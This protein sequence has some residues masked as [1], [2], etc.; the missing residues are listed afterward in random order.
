MGKP[1]ISIVM[2]SHNDEP[3]IGRTLAG[4]RSQRCSRSFEI[5][6]IDDSSTDRTRELIADYPDVRRIDPP[7]GVY[8]PG[9][10]LNAAVRACRGEVVVFNNADAIPLDGEWLERLTSPL[11]AEPDVAAAFANQLPRS[12]AFWLVRK[13]SYRAYGDGKIAAKWGFFF[14]LASS[15]ARREELTQHPFSLTLRSSEDIDWA[16]RAVRRGKVLRYVP[17][18]RVEHSHNYGWTALWRRFYSEGGSSAQIF[19][20]V[21]GFFGS[22]GRAGVETL[23]DFAFLA[24]HPGGWRELPA[25][26][27][28]RL[29][30]QMAFRRGGLAACSRKRGE[31]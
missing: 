28:R 13:D 17:E 31:S 1:E 14:S 19:G 3:Y 25:A 8:I 9:K 30:Q 23:R 10:T 7:P 21:P 29:I 5:V 27:V 6:S 18:A 11:F 15:A 24:V 26:P 20:K 22:L 4:F 12:D 16:W 2:R